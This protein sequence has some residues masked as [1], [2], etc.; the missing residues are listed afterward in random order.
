MLVEHGTYLE[1]K[2]REEHMALISPEDRQTLQ[3]LF[4]QE[5]QD[6]VNETWSNES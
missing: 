5:L 4:A 1:E 6:D 3:T 2:E